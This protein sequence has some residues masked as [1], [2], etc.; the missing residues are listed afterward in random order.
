MWPLA[1]MEPRAYEHAEAESLLLLYR[2]IAIH[3]QILQPLPHAARPGYLD[4]L[5]GRV[6][7]G[8]EENLDASFPVRKDER[9]SAANQS[10]PTCGKR[11]HD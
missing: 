5:H 2:Q 7:S 1:W 10:R 9:V 3:G 4:P 11:S 6:L 8:S